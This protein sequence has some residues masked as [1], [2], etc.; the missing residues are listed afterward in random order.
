MVLIENK[1]I[2]VYFLKKKK[3]KCH[4]QMV[5]NVI[6]IMKITKKKNIN[7]KETNL[8]IEIGVLFR[9]KHNNL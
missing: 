1:D 8:K 3:D 9:N 7:M 4:S 5:K 2:Y 6:I